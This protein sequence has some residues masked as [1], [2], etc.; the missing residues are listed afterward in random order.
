MIQRIQSLFIL[1]AAGFGIALFFVSLISLKSSDNIIVFSAS[2]AWYLVVLLSINILIMFIYLFGY[3]NR[4][5]QMLTGKISIYLWILW[6]LLFSLFVYLQYNMQDVT[7]ITVHF[8]AIFPCL[9]IIFILLANRN[10]KKDEDL[11]RSM[12]RIR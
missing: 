6:L 12:D 9:I 4:K 8:G 7:N 3:K 2:K 1:A 10:I 5:K 11:I